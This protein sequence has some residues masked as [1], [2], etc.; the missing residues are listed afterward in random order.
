LVVKV[1][2]L[3]ISPEEFGRI[4]RQVNEV[5]ET[6]V[7]TGFWVFIA[8]YATC[9]CTFGCSM[10]PSWYLKNGVF[11]SSSFSPIPPQ[12]Q[13]RSPTCASF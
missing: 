11:G 1:L 4:M 3:Q 9:C 8:G 12:I 5:L 2:V 10:I 13:P 7:S 6:E